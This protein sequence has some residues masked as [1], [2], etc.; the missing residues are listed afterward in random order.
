MYLYHYL[1]K[2]NYIFSDTFS[3]DGVQHLMLLHNLM[4]DVC[5]KVHITGLAIISFSPRTAK[6]LLSNFVNVGALGGKEPRV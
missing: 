5:F 3:Q 6:P 1:F 4:R 2:N